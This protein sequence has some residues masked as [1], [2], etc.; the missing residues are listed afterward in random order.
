MN[1]DNRED[2]LVFVEQ[3]EGGAVKVGLEALGPAQV[4]A[5]LTGGKVIGLVM[6]ED[7]AA[8]VDKV[9]VLCDEVISVEDENFKDGNNDALTYGLEKIVEKVNPAAILAGNTPL[10]REL[11]ARLGKRLGLGSAQDVIDLKTEGDQILW[12]VPVYGGTVLNDIEL[13]TLP[14]MATVRSGAFSKPEEKQKAEIV[15]ETVE[16][17]EEEI[18]SKVVDSVKEISEAVNLEEAK[19]IVTGGRGMGSKENYHL[20]EELADL[21]GGVVGATRPAIEDEWVSRDHQVGQSGKIVSPALY[22]ACGVS[23]ATQHVTGMTNSGYIV[24]INKDED[25]PIFDV[26][27]VGIVGDVM[28]VIP[29]MIEEIKKRKE[30]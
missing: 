13:K 4:L 1:W 5:G 30:E 15:T 8:A 21:L 11:T 18:R 2:V 24:A 23:G 22:I 16:V 6:G 9:S 25:A 3:K 27:D 20:V 17:P 19:V 7:N 12:T 28:K 10:G 14:L 26:A 29:V